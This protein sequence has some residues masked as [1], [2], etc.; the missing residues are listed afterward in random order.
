MQFL[1]HLIPKNDVPGKIGHIITE[2][3]AYKTC[4]GER[5]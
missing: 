3:L 4:L 1:E 5:A 2:S